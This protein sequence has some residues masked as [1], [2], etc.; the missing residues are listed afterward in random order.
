VTPSAL[1]EAVRGAVAAAGLQAPDALA[2]QA[3]RNPEHGDYASNVALQLAKPA[4]RNPRELAT[5]LATLLCDVEGVAAVDV[6]GPGFLNITLV[7]GT[8]GQLAAD[9]VA[10]RMAYGTNSTLAGQHLNVEFVSANPTGPLHVGGVRWAAVGDALARVLQ[11]CGAL[12]TREYYVNDA[13]NQVGLFADS[14]DAVARGLPVPENGYQG[15]YIA[16]YAAQCAALQPGITELADTERHAAYQQLGLRVV[17]ADIRQAL[18]GFGVHF[19][20]WFSEASL[21]SSGAVDRALTRLR[22]LGKVYE[23]DGATWLRTTDFGDDKDRVLVKGDGEST[24]FTSDCAYYL[25]KRSRGADRVIIMLGADHHGYLGR[26]KAMA[27]CFGD[28]PALTLELQIGQLVNVVQGGESV[29]MSKRAGTFLTLAEIVELVG[30]DAARYSLARSSADSPMDLDVDLLRQQSS[31]NPVFYVQY[32]HARFSRVLATAGDLGID[33]READPSLLVQDRETELLRAIGEWP[34][35]VASAGE[36]R[37]PHRIARFLEETLAPAGQRFYDSCRALPMGEDPV[38]EL[39]RARLLLVSA[40]RTV[41]ANGLALLG[42][43]APER[44]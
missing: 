21:Q 34:R 13:G 11:A 23:A 10:A 8:L 44:M 4:G 16:D 32:A 15:D 36:L 12:V 2:L 28:D 39:N 29:K 38:T 26:M 31:D 43:S 35:V 42:V 9:V 22:E 27:A 33:L 37:A 7:K 14:L 1:A 24:Y 17:L 18:E 20:V 5:E 3:P 30:V 25:D 40:T 19:D 6:A 41:L